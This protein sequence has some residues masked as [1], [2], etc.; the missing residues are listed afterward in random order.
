MQKAGIRLQQLSARLAMVAQLVPGG[1]VVADIGTD[2]A[3]LPVHLVRHGISPRVV[4]ADIAPGPLQNAEKT[5]Q[6][7][8]LQHE[9][10]LR[11]SNG[12]ENFL[13]EDA[14]C[15]VL[16]GMGGTLMVRLLSA[17]PWLQRP[18]TVLVAQPQSRANELYG[19]LLP[20]GFC[21]EQELV[22]RDAGRVYTAVRAR[23]KGE[24]P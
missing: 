16:A 10:Q 4:A 13:P 24:L 20:H 6:R 14:Q 9:I 7:A 5:I 18:G 15:W 11:Q 22:C 2:H 17:A 3:Y 8:G 23:Y 19:W 21:V 1:M 12:F